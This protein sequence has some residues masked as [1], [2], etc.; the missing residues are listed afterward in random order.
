MVIENC[1]VRI[2]P[3]NSCLIVGL[4]HKIRQH[5]SHS[6]CHRTLHRKCEAWNVVGFLNA[7]QCY[8]K[9]AFVLAK[10]AKLITQRSIF[11]IID[12]RVDFGEVVT[13]Q[14]LNYRTCVALTG[15]EC[16]SH[17]NAFAF[18]Y[19]SACDVGNRLAQHI[20]KLLRRNK[21]LPRCGTFIQYVI[22]RKKVLQ[23]DKVRIFICHGHKKVF[24]A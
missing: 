9:I 8:G 4:H 10:I 17:P 5:F 7:F 18:A 3:I 1:T 11:D 24:R 13:Q 21:T 6:L 19:F 20:D 12:V 16:A 2:N 14:V 22:Y 23:V 15:A